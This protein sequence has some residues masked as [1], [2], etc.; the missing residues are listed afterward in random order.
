MKPHITRIAAHKLAKVIL[1]EICDRVGHYPFH[2]GYSYMC[3]E[4][5]VAVNAA[6]FVESRVAWVWWVRKVDADKIMFVAFRGD[7]VVHVWMVPA[8][9]VREDG[10]FLVREDEVD[11]WIEYE[12]DVSQH[13]KNLL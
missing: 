12:I 3:D 13:I 7:E 2:F 1:H 11:V 6:T 5:K 9:M 10:R 4:Q 8:G